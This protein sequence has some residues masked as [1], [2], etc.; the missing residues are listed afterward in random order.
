M[1]VK[2]T[3]KEEFESQMAELAKLEVGSDKYKLTV[4]G[5]TKLADRIIEI[6]KNEKDAELKE[7]QIGNEAESI[8]AEINNNRTRNVI[9]VVKVGV[10]VAAAFAMGIISMKWEKLDT[11]TSSAGKSALR[12]ILR[13]K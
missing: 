10:P 2:Q 5:V 1:S 9:E 4:D 12:D 3:L 11:L 13:F 6:E 7:Y 8:N